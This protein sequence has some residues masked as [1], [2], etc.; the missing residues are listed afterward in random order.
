M[1]GTDY[2]TLKVNELKDLLSA[3]GLSTAGRKEELIARLAEHDE[4]SGSSAGKP[5]TSDL[6]D[7]AP[8]EEEV[9]WGDDGEGAS[10]VKEVPEGST[11]ASEPPKVAPEATAAAAPETT[12]GPAAQ[13]A[14]KDAP[15]EP[16]PTT[17]SEGAGA[18]SVPQASIDVDA[19]LEKRRKRAERFGIK[20]GAEDDKKAARAERFGTSAQTDAAAA[21]D[22]LAGALPS[23]K[24]NRRRNE[25]RQ[26][27]KRPFSAV[28]TSDKKTPATAYKLDAAEQ[29]KARKR[30]ER[31]GT[32]A[33][34][35]S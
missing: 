35:A 26:E 8:P 12:Q 16:G 25:H 21:V 3:A 7:L 32:A 34:T 4:A 13:D 30:A 17:S 27:K 20:L 1:A 10:E 14:S 5:K 11:K 18:P 33:K 22:V 24:G 28:E 23:G 15:K 19:E 2:K 6:G 9:D 29:E 31:F